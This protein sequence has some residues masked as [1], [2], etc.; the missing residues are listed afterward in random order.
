V[1]KADRLRRDVE[2]R[3][4]RFLASGDRKVVL[5]AGAK[6]AAE[7]L[8]K[9]AQSTFHGQPALNIDDAYVLG[10]YYWCRYLALPPEDRAAEL[11]HCRLYF[12]GLI[13]VAPDLIPDELRGEITD[14]D[15]RAQAV[16]VYRGQMSASYEIYERAQLSQDVEGLDSAIELLRE[17]PEQDLPDSLA[18]SYHGSLMEVLEKRYRWTGEIGDLERAIAECHLSLAKTSPR[19]DDERRRLANLDDLVMERYKEIGTAEHLDDVITVRRSR[20]AAATEE[21]RANARTMLASML[22]R[23]YLERSE[24]ADLQEALRECRVGLAEAKD[25]NNSYILAELSQLLVLAYTE[26]LPDVSSPEVI[27][28]IEAA[29]AARPS[30]ND[31]VSATMRANL[32]TFQMERYLQDGDSTALVD[33]LEHAQEA[34]DVFSPEDDLYCLARDRLA[35][36]LLLRDERAAREAAVGGFGVFISPDRPLDI[37][38]SCVEQTPRGNPRRIPALESLASAY[39][40]SAQIYDKPDLLDLAVDT[41]LAILDELTGEDDRGEALRNLAM[42]LHQRYQSTGQIPDLAKAI[43]LSRESIAAASVS[44]R[45]ELKARLTLA[46]TL[47][48]RLDID[49]SSEEERQFAIDTYRECAFTE[50]LGVAARIWAARGWATLA[51]DAGWYSVALAGYEAMLALTPDIAPVNLDDADRLRRMEEGE[52]WAYRAAACAI[53][54]GQ[55]EHAVEMLERSRMVTA[56]AVAVSVA[57]LDSLRRQHPDMANKVEAAH[58]A[59]AAV[60]LGNQ[61]GFATA[62]I[63]VAQ[64]G[65]REKRSHLEDAA[66]TWQDIVAQ[67]RNVAGFKSFLTPATFAMLQSASAAGPVAVLNASPHRCDALIMVN[68]EV[69][70]LPLATTY[71]EVVEWAN[72]YLAVVENI[73]RGMV[74]L[75][76]RAAAEAEI[77]RVLRWLWDS[78]VNPTLEMLGL[79]SIVTDDRWP[80]LWWSP[81]GVFSLFPLHAAEAATEDGAMDRVQSSYAPS[82][83]LLAHVNQQADD[84]HGSRPGSSPRLLAV[85]LTNT[86]R[87]ENSMLPNVPRELATV[88]SAFSPAQQT[89]LCDDQATRRAVEQA[90]PLHDWLHFACHSLQYPHNP[91]WSALHLY[92]RP[93]SVGDLRWSDLHGTRLAVLSACQTAV[94][95][96]KLLGEGLHLGAAM[97][98][99]GCRDVVGTLWTVRDSSAVEFVDQ[100]YRH[101]RHDDQI[102]GHRAAVG[103]HLAV[104]ELR[105]R[106]P[107]LYASWASFIHVGGGQ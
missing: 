46:E 90:L 71:T 101:L 13:N 65:M 31:K 14:A 72:R 4:R 64:E 35:Q 49:P 100:L 17:V 22:E 58:T 93:L 20:L 37:L 40:K 28:T 2:D 81:S 79:T 24:L 74:A 30:G 10:S 102:D 54:L 97:H 52:G 39:E 29:L 8:A 105:S 60:A 95:G 36:A 76:E 21:N 45:E 80:R 38:R 25:D 27:S 44:T 87:L 12:S 57:D 34:V 56:P 16:T 82:L 62:P 3:I 7:R 106:V 1:D 91:S 94:G 55:P 67:I 104:R 6:R 103:V 41:Y 5:A 61:V 83:R 19:T 50:S 42:A 68:N 107:D 48:T 78:T 73:N 99:A 89:I 96:V 63:I 53:A 15:R 18:A 9:H 23:R 32:A 51:H 47:A 92:D 43:Q 69:N 84:R 26:D 85:G 75:T 86:P 66:A 33:A 59:L 98:V 77:G 11:E 70:V 88:S